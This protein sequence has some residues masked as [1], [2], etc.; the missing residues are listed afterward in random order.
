MGQVL[1]Y[2]F[3]I[4][5][6]SAVFGFFMSIY[7]KFMTSAAIDDGSNLAYNLGGAAILCIVGV[8]VFIQ[9][10]SK[11]ASLGGGIALNLGAAAGK[12]RNAGSD[13]GG[14]AAKA[15]SAGASVASAVGGAAG[16]AA[17]YFRGSGK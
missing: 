1:S 14:A 7:T 8:L 17:N 10:P 2:A 12:A 15:D 4:I 5:M 11:A 13:I 9:I 16:K 3:L 6:M